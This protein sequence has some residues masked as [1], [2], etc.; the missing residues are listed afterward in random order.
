MAYNSIQ[1]AWRTD[2]YDAI[3]AILFGVCLVLPGIGWMFGWQ[4]TTLVENRSLALPPDFERTSLAK[5]PTEIDAYY[6]DHVG[7]RGAM[8][9]V[10][11][12]ILHRILR[13]SSSEVMIGKSANGDEPWYFYAAENNL[14]FSRS[15]LQW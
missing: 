4:G 8:I 2:R 12:M 15:R 6:N 14:L 9:R 7:F 10:T 13:S 11:G 3:L 1:A 5:W